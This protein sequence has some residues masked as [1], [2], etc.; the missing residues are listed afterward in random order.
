MLQSMPVLDYESQHVYVIE[1]EATD[2]AGL[3][4]ST[5][6]TIQITDDND[7]PI[8][9]S[10]PDAIFLDEDSAPGKMIYNVTADDA[11]GDVI[12]FNIVTSPIGDTFRVT[13]KGVC[14][15][16]LVL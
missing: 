10:L 5:N 11:D 13:E 15:F 6:L 8:I 4:S 2:T 7:A 1:I 3:S 9:T 16:I 14:L 12:S